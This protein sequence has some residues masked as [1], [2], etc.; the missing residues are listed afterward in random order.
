M[1]PVLAIV[2]DID[3]GSLGGNHRALR[4]W[5]SL[6]FF[7]PL[8]FRRL[9]PTYVLNLATFFFFFHVVSPGSSIAVRVV[10]QNEIV[11]GADSRISHREFDGSIT[12]VRDDACKVCPIENGLLVWAG[13][14]DLP[15]CELARAAADRTEVTSERLDQFIVDASRS[16]EELIRSRP[17]AYWA[18]TPI[19]VAFVQTEGTRATWAHVM[20]FAGAGVP[21]QVVPKAKEV[22]PPK[23]DRP[24]FFIGSTVAWS[25]ERT[26]SRYLGTLS[27]I[28]FVRSVVE[29]VM[30]TDPS[31][32]GKMAIATVYVGRLVAWT[33]NGA[34]A[35]INPKPKPASNRK[36]RKPGQ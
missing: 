11:I 17:N 24:F 36:K 6:V 30:G 25:Y 27:G 4:N 35:H 10:S 23:C 16:F 28:D 21:A 32:G 15:Y 5:V 20:L 13:P 7:I 19:E 29:N 33:S 14:E 26:N 34:C 2:A 31:V 12:T 18:G 1:K 3:V 9:R 8:I 22:C